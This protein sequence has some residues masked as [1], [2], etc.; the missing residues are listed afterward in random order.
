MALAGL[1]V[2]LCQVPTRKPLL[3]LGSTDTSSKGCKLGKRKQ[4]SAHYALLL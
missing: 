3:R 1:R 4:P 2:Q